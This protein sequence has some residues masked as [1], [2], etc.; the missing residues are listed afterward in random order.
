MKILHVISAVHKQGGG[1]SEV[2][3]R[4]CRAQ[5]DAG[6]EV[7]LIAL[8][9]DD[10]SVQA[11]LAMM[12]GVEFEFVD[13]MI[14]FPVIRSIG[15]A[16]GFYKKVESAIART[17]IVHIHGLWMCPIWEAAKAARKLG[18]PYVVM[19][20]GFLEPERLKISKWKKRISAVLFD[21]RVLK[22]ANAII[23]TSENEA[24]GIRAFG[25]D[26]PIRLMPLGLDVELFDASPQVSVIIYIT[27]YPFGNMPLPQLP[28]ICS[29]IG[30][31]HTSP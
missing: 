1:T 14:N 12:S 19:P 17:D 26:N 18:K 9:T 22:D 6:H 20:H 13:G 10:V 4:I 21:R 31:E 11:E 27:Q 25:L 3:P 24:Q 29:A 7:S 2:V 28:S 15:Y 5:K 30:L 8:K 16:S 23:A